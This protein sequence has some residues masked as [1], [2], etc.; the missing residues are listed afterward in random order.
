[1]KKP[2]LK[3]FLEIIKIN[4]P[5]GLECNMIFY[6]KSWL[7]QHNVSFKVDKVGNIL[8]RING[9][10]NPI[11][12]CVHLDTVE[13]GKAIKPVFTNEIIKSSGDTILGADNKAT[14]ACLLCAVEKYLSD[15]KKHL[16]A[17]ELLFT[18]KEEVGGGVE[19]FPFKW[20]KSKVG[21]IF[22]SAKPLASI[23]LQS[24]YIT[25]FHAVINGKACHSSQPQK[26]INAFMPA[27]KALNKIKTGQVDGGKTTINVGKLAGGTGINIVPDKI[28]ISGEVRSYSKNLF[29]KNLTKIK[30]LFNKEAKLYKAGFNFLTAG[31][32]PGYKHDKNSLFI[33]KTYKIL[34]DSGFKPKYYYKSAVSDANI[35]NYAG[36]TT[37]N[38]GDGVKNPHSSKESIALNDLQK[39]TEIIGTFLLS[40]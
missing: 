31:F 37:V 32:C 27:I 39:L 24:P 18:V 13:P 5:S 21:Y 29:E 2:V 4:S 40:Y 19:Y 28:T 34:A 23:I 33:K 3:T 14:I 6:I 16:R 1:M 17:F 8:A 36:I 11:L 7:K 30:N 25:N 35:L 9:S 20:V 15:N 22:D 26:G 12:F 10:G 38:L